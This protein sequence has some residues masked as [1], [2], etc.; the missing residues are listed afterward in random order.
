[1]WSG[2]GS[3]SRVG[4]SLWLTGF[5]A[6][7]LLILTA[8]AHSVKRQ[9]IACPQS[10]LERWPIPAAWL[11]EK[12]D[13]EQVESDHMYQGVPFGRMNDEWKELLD[14]R[15]DGDQLWSYDSRQN[16]GMEGYLL[17]R[18]CE[19]VYNLVTAQYE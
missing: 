1:M 8:C 6:C 4:S 17:V 18:D 13:F 10:T 2:R 9:R 11:I 12:V 7:L 19:V 5:L 16:W 15:R 14:Q 3:K